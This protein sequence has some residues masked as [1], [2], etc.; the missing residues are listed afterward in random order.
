MKFSKSHLDRLFKGTS[1]LPSRHFVQVFLE[2]TSSANGIK[3]EIHRDLCRRADDLLNAARKYRHRRRS[4]KFPE[5][6]PQVPSEVAVANLKVQLELERA[7]RTEDRLRWAL[8]DAQLL[9]T[10]LL[11]IISTLRE[12]VM[13]LDTKHLRE[14]RNSAESETV[15]VTVNQRIQALRH[16]VTAENQLERANDRRVLLEN[17]WTQ[18][19]NNVN[20]LSLH[21]DVT[22]V[23]DFPAGPALPQREL[24]STAIPPQPALADIAAALDKAQKINNTEERNAHELQRSLTPDTHLQPID[25]LNTLLAATQLTDTASRETALRALIRDWSRNPK[26]RDT[27]VRLTVDDQPDIRALATLHLARTWSNDTAA[28]QA[29]ITVIHDSELKVR[30]IAVWGL[31]RSWAGDFTAL[32][33]LVSLTQDR[34]KQSRE[35]AA[36]GLAEGWPGNAVARDALLVLLQDAVQQ[37]REAAIDVL[38]EKWPSDVV[39]RDTLLA[40]SRTTATDLAMR[41]VAVNGLSLGWPNDASVV[42]ALLAML[43][44]SAPTVRWAAERGL[45]LKGQAAIK[46]RTG[47]PKNKHPRDVGKPKSMDSASPEPE[48]DP[49]EYG[50]LISARVPA[51]YSTE[52]PVSGIATL[53]RG[54]RFNPGV[55]VIYG[56]NGTGKT[57]FLKSLAVRLGAIKGSRLRQ[58]VQV[59]PWVKDLAANL[60]ILLAEDFRSEDC[61]YMDWIENR[62]ARREKLEEELAGVPRYRLYLLDEPTASRDFGATNRLFKKMYQFSQQGCQFIMVTSDMARPRPIAPID[63]KVTR[64]GSHRLRD[65]MAS[66]G[67]AAPSDGAGQGPR[68]TVRAHDAQ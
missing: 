2:I 54:I 33:A 47:L 65:R 14:L 32:C 13:D 10:T 15:E 26:T 22:E 68:R 50:P 6:V 66:L 64:F 5:S 55:N 9:M 21:P 62:H 36:E 46:P 19:H 53:R 30:S 4:N 8:S 11:Q 67:W 3:P 51:E 60:E 29:L 20:R 35:L 25:E 38:L 42:N 61:F 40:L 41:E 39:T 48:A 58:I 63:A 49:S 44:D 1:S 56:D 23:K 17:L 43:N 18:A 37:V 28:R 7:H 57:L 24:L 45:T 16:K 27:I 12:I 59:S 52:D 31:A 34:S